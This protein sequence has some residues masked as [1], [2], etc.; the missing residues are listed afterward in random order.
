MPRRATDPV[1]NYNF[2]VEIDGV[3]NGA[4]SEVSGLDSE[5]E[6]IE[7]RAGNDVNPSVR[8]IPGLHKFGDVTLKRGITGS[9]GIWQWRKQV[10]DGQ[11]ER[12]GVSIILLD[13]ARAEVMRWNLFEAWPAKYAGPMLAATGNEV[14]IETLV[15]VCERIELG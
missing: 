10:V 6:V 3:G 12:R 13:E 7:Y 5:T 8:K 1:G 9:N 2:I 4:F 15:I 14:A 11:I